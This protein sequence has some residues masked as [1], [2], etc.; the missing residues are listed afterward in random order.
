M[1]TYRTRLSSSLLTPRESLGGNI[2]YY[3]IESVQ[4]MCTIYGAKGCNFAI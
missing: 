1:R 3:I 4:D 2:V